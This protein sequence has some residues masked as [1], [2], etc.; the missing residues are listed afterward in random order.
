MMEMDEQ[1]KEKGRSAKEEEDESVVCSW[2]KSSVSP[3]N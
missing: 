1:E 2:S 3:L